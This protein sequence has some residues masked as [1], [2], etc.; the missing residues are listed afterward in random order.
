MLP[1]QRELWRL[2]STLP[3]PAALNLAFGLLLDGPFDPSAMEWALQELVNRHEP[4]RSAH[5]GPGNGPATEVLSPVDMRLEYVELSSAT[6]SSRVMDLLGRFAKA[7]DRE[8]EAPPLL[9]AQ[10]L[11][12]EPDQHLLL[13]TFNHLAVDGWAL[14]L[15]CREAELLYGARIPLCQ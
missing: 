15:F 3:R 9:R 14:E 11:L 4:L 6:G 5:S 12:L 10:C 13:L 1:T 8:V 2:R 7:V